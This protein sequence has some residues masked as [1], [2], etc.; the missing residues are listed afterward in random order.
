[1]YLATRRWVPVLHSEHFAPQC[2]GT[3][4]RPNDNNIPHPRRRRREGQARAAARRPQRAHG[5]WPRQRRH[6]A[7]ARR[8]DHHAR[9]P[10]RAARSSCSRISA[11][12]RDATPRIRSKPV[13]EALS[14][15]SS[16]PVAF[17]DDCIG[18][19]AAKAVAAMKDGDILLPRKH[20]LPRGRG[21]ERSGLR[22][23][24]GEARRHLGQRR[25]LGGAPRPRLDRRPRPQA[26]G[27]CRPHHAG[28][29]R[30][31]GE[32][33]GSADQAGHRD[34]RRRQGLDQDRP[35]RKPRDQGRRAGDR[36]RHGQHLPA[37]A[38]R[39]RRQVAG[40]EGSRARPRCASW[41]RRKPPTAPSSCRS[42][43]WSPI[44]SRPM[45]RRTP[46]GSTRSRPTA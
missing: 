35:A 3:R 40:R 22:R 30:R 26:A 13:A 41:R 16:K 2:A 34:H 25:L 44:I 29:A 46:T 39:R 42:T 36:R 38:G 9:S 27:L 1:M 11:G 4:E 37:R 19:P 43:P 5:Q 21:K 18:E 23:G 7:R 45:R 10:T 24:A 8:A 17:A 15:V 33:A 12:R 6:P 14:Q 31:A 32:G 28:R 20:P